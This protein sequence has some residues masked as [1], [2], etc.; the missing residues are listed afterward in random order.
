M[1]AI[2]AGTIPEGRCFLHADH[3]DSHDSRYAGIGLVPRAR[4]LGRAIAMPDM[5]WLGLEGPLV[6]PEDNLPAAGRVRGGLRGG[7]GGPAARPDVLVRGLPG[8]DVSADRQRRGP[9]RRRAGIAACRPAPGLPAAPG[10]HR[11]GE[12]GVLQDFVAGAPEAKVAARVVELVAI[13]RDGD[14]LAGRDEGLAKGWPCRSEALRF[15]DT[16]LCVL[17]VTKCGGHRT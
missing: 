11:L 9:C 15:E 1:T 6:G 5:P 13:A 8:R 7:L 12:V 2:A 10:G 4:I 16:A 3:P 14:R 17:E